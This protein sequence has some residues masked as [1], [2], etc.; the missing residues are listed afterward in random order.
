[1]PFNSHTDM[2]IA[3]GDEQGQWSVAAANEGAATGTVMV[4]T[5]ANGTDSPIV[6]V[7][8]GIHNTTNSSAIAGGGSGG[9]KADAGVPPSLTANVQ[10][11]GWYHEVVAP[12]PSSLE[13]NPWGA[14]P[15]EM[16]GHGEGQH[17]Q[18][19][20][21]QQQQT[22]PPQQQT[23]PPQQPQPPQQQQQQQQQQQPPP[24]PQQ[25]QLQQPVSG[26]LQSAPPALLVQHG[27]DVIQ[28]GLVVNA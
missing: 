14:G 13:H 23:Q 21:P 15:N 28:A 1:M 18:Q 20:P 5:T 8:T 25:Q 22:Q 17:Q 27:G 10:A 3:Q 9:D 12:L 19:Q 2:S 26:S 6:S 7:I 16:F 11:D 24:Q 4:T